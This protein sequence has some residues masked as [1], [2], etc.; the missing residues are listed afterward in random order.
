[1]I[2]TRGKANKIRLKKEFVF[3]SVDFQFCENSIYY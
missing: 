3:V 1:M 2:N